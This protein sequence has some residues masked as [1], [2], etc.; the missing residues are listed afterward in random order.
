MP[1]KRNKEH[2]N[3]RYVL[4][5]SKP[6]N[7]LKNI[8]RLQNKLSFK[9]V[10]QGVWHSFPCWD[11][12]SNQLCFPGFNSQYQGSNIS[13]PGCNPLILLGSIQ[14]LGNTSM[15]TTNISVK[16]LFTDTNLESHP[17]IFSFFLEF[18]QRGQVRIQTCECTFPD[19]VW[20][21]SGRGGC[22]WGPGGWGAIT[23]FQTV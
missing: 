18:F 23:P 21:F 6:K 2:E 12:I 16:I 14:F 11:K 22:V 10:T 4:F 3:A 15:N 17:D 8:F 1:G 7:T 9:S 5:P 13:D 20:T 19:H